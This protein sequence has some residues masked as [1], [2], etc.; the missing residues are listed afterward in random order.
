MKHRVKLKRI[1]KKLFL[2]ALIGIVF[3]V[4]I[5]TYINNYASD[6][7]FNDIDALPKTSYGLVLGTSKYMIGGGKN[8]YFEARIES[9]AQLYKAKKIGT[10]L[11]SGDNREAN[12][13]EPDRMK[14]ALI[15][16]GVPENDIIEEKNGYNTI[17]SIRNFKNL[18]PDEK[19]TIITQKFHNERAVFFAL[20]LD[21][22]AVGFNAPDINFL[23]DPKT[24][25]REW[26][27][28]IK[29]L[30]YV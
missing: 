10:I 22:E 15:E 26:F 23:R 20:K 6:F 12:Y 9:A 3:I 29:A 19:V 21:I 28:K 5:N 11:V 7:L 8:P 13:N 17:N 16:L 4:S 18:Y 25:I 1:I 24:H 14:Q 30:L 2:L 27:A